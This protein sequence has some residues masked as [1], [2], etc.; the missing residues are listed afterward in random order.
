MK[1][2]DIKLQGIAIY[3][4]G[5]IPYTFIIE[6]ISILQFWCFFD[7]LYCL[8]V[9]NVRSFALEF[10]SYFWICELIWKYEKRKTL[11][12]QNQKHHL[13]D[14]A[15]HTHFNSSTYHL[16]VREYISSKTIHHFEH[17]KN[18]QS[19]PLTAHQNIKTQELKQQKKKIVISVVTWQPTSTKHKTDRYLMPSSVISFL[20]ISF[21]CM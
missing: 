1:Q 21:V 13:N 17:F 2:R 8:L 16:K 12:Q 10:E 4:T 19:L 3:S 20:Q 7:V 9:H 14:V 18:V 15:V 6:L 11:L 5:N